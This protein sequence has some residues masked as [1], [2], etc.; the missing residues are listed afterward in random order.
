MPRKKKLGELLG[1]PRAQVGA[2]NAPRSLQPVDRAPVVAPKRRRPRA[3]R[4][5]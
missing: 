4:S 5:Y 1:S 2:R 3:R